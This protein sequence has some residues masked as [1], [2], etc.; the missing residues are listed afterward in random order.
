MSS[1][2]SE[3]FRRGVQIQKR[4]LIAW[5]AALVLL[6]LSVVSAWP[7]MES[8]APWRTSPP[9]SRRSWPRHRG[10]PDRQ[11]QR[12]PQGQPVR[13][14][15]AAAPRPDGRHRH[16]RPDR[17]RR[18]GRAARTAACAAGRP[19]RG[20]PGPLPL[21]GLRP[22]PHQRPGLAVGVRL[23]RL[24]RH[25]RLR[26][27]GGGGSAD[28]R[29]AGGAARGYRV[30]HRRVRL[31]GPV[32]RWAWRRACSSSGTCCTASRRCPTPWNRSAN[33]SPGSGRWAATR[34]STASLGELLVA[35]SVVVVAAGTYAV[36]RRDNTNA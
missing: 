21:R 7:S 29:P 28:R 15:A 6:A 25:G 30:R 2:S 17:R 18:G 20:V 4:T 11:R 24:P 34:C 32:P 31:Q 33:V 13:R 22:G 9:A 23:G 36:D 14:P 35:V 1:P 8:S 26:G 12:L 10:R 19:P 3:I 16:H 27:R 5:S